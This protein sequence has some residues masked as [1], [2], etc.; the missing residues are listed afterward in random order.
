MFAVAPGSLARLLG[1]PTVSDGPYG[2]LR[3]ADAN[4][5]MLPAGFSSRIIARSGHRVAGT[6]YIWHDAPDGGATFGTADGGW[7]YVSNSETNAPRGG[8][9]AVRF[10]RRGMITG[11][12][13]ILD[14]TS[15]NC[16]G[17]PTPWGMWLSCEEFARGRVWE[18]DPTGQRAATVRPALGVFQHES[19]AVDPVNKRIYLTEDEPDGRFYRFTPEAYPKLDAGVLEVADVAPDGGTQ[20]RIVPDPLAKGRPTRRQVVQS[21]RFAGGEGT[22][23]HG[24]SV[25]FTTKGDNR[26]WSYDTRE[27]RLSVLY[28]AGRYRQ[29]SLS[30]VDNVTVSPAGDVLVAE[31]GGDME[32]VM[33]TPDDRIARLLRVVGGAHA[34][35]E[36]AGPAFDPS[37]TRLYFSSQRGYGRGVTFE[38][39]GPF[40]TRRPPQPTLAAQPIDTPSPEPLPLAQD[41]PGPP[42]WALAAGAAAGAGIAGVASVNHRRRR[43]RRAAP[44]DA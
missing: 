25:Y 19:A 3:P 23:Y 13:R 32:I 27:D 35:S 24:A 39:R 21:T 37:G 42:A 34:G 26:V 33:I 20:W 1:T 28:D 18:C 9:G 14:G 44:P 29:P 15:R 40:R 22:W 8:T 12:Y 4:G 11:A 6:A 5:L 7:I 17:G 31:D 43:R 10:D 41:E 36:I 2:P 16:A 38:V 30:G